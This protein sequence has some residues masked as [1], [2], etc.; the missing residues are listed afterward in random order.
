MYP[1]AKDKNAV[2]MFCVAK[3]DQPVKPRFMTDCRIRNLAVYKK[4]ILLPNIVELIELV[5]AY[6]V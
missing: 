4:Q 1:A 3:R 2:V 5:T 6:I